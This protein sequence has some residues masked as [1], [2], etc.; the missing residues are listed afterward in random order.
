MELIGG[1][2]ASRM[3]PSL[4]P[5]FSRC[6]PARG[7]HDDRQQPGGSSVEVTL[8]RS[9]LLNLDHLGLITA[10]CVLDHFPADY[11]ITCGKKWHSFCY[12][13]PA[14]ISVSDLGNATPHQRSYSAGRRCPFGTPPIPV[15]LSH[16][17]RD[18]VQYQSGR[19]G[20]RYH[21]PSGGPPDS[22]A[23]TRDAAR[24][25]VSA[26]LAVACP[27]RPTGPS[28]VIE[29]PPAA[30]LIQPVTGLRHPFIPVR[31]NR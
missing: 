28:G 21:A 29:R 7:M 24:C 22:H 6:Q 30:P 18:R 11:P 17:G 2:F 16:V 15:S 1:R 8:R 12:F 4:I 23:T 3:K 27:R 20:R 13:F 19:R 14:G 5:P 31:T 26:A 10:Q 9:H 25:I